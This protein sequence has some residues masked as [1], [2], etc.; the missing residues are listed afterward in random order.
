M[1]YAVEIYFDN[2]TTSKIQAVWANIVSAGLDSFIPQSG[3]RPHISLG[4]YDALDPETM[5]P[6]V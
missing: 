3:A 5:R 4:V 2:E 6:V 1:G